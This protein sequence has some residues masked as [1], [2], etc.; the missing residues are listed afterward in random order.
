MITSDIEMNEGNH[1][2]IEGMSI[3]FLDLEF[4]MDHMMPMSI[5]MKDIIDNKGPVMGL[6]AILAR[7]LSEG[8][9]PS[10]STKNR[11]GWYGLPVGSYKADV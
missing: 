7:L 4:H 10:G 1:K 6:R 9:I 5:L 2:S 11:S 8:S 3:D